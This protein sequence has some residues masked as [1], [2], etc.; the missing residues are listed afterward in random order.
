ML[1]HLEVAFIVKELFDLILYSS[2][3][4]D[5]QISLGFSYSLSFRKIYGIY[6]LYD[7]SSFK[8]KGNLPEIFGIIFNIENITCNV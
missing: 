5:W 3:L 6:H 4:N 8:P 7:T 2:L 1:L